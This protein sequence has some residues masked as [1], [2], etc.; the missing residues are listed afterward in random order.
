MPVQPP[1]RRSARAMLGIRSSHEVACLRSLSPGGGFRMQRRRAGRHRRSG[2]DQPQFVQAPFH[3]NRDTIVTIR[4]RATTPG[5][6]SATSRPAAAVGQAHRPRRIA[7]ITLTAD[8]V[9]G[10]RGQVDDHVARL[11]GTD[12]ELPV[13]LAER[14]RAE[15]EYPRAFP[16]WLAGASRPQDHATNAFRQ[17]GRSA[18]ARRLTTCSLTSGM[19]LACHGVT[20]RQTTGP[21]AC[22]PR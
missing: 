15:T 21:A 2:F 14:P 22:G 19:S 13:N 4:T 16:A 9:T 1:I 3:P 20:I 18:P 8:A 6:R 5:G 10:A 17:H 11:G 12:A 7:E